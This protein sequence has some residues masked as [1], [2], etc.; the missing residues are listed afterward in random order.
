MDNSEISNSEPTLTAPAAP[1][2]NA[3][4]NGVK[5]SVNIFIVTPDMIAKGFGMPQAVQSVAKEATPCVRRR[6]SEQK[7][8]ATKYEFLQLM[9]KGD[10]YACLQWVTTNCPEFFDSWNVSVKDCGSYKGKMRVKLTQVFYT[11]LRQKNCPILK[12][13]RGVFQGTLSAKDIH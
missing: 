6:R 8:R 2:L 5:G 10:I 13:G 11:L 7:L 1:W 9:P 12:L 4:L 3:L